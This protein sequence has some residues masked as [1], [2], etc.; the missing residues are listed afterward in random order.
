MK[1]HFQFLIRVFTCPYLSRNFSFYLSL[2]DLAAVAK[3]AV[4]GDQGALDLFDWNKPGQQKF[5]M[6]QAES[7][8]MYF[9][10]KDGN[11]VFFFIIIME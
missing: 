9:G 3:A 4:S 11:F 10:T 2:S 1:H 7:I 6:G 8:Q 5:S